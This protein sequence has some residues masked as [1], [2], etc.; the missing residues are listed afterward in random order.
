MK[1]LDDTFI[2]IC[3]DTA[4]NLAGHKRRAYQA[5]ITQTYLQGST[6]RAESLFGWAR[7]TVALGLKEL[8]SGYICY[9]EI[10]ERGDKR[11]EEKLPHV[12]EAIEELVEPSSQADPTFQSPFAYTRI[13][14]R[15]VRQAL[16]DIKGY[17]D[18]QLPTERT[19]RNILNRLG[20]KLR[21]VQKAKPK[22]N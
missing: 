3:I 8:E 2:Q 22:K 12:A 15:A 10:H 9:V 1:T 6:R 18:E 14:A 7:A 11:T 5:M 20:Y 19:I 17:T 21:R 13:T 4:K 16:I